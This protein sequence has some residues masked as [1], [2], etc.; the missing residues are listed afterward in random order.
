MSLLSYKLLETDF[1]N[2]AGFSYVYVPFNLVEA[3]L[4]LACA[5]YVLLRALRR[6]NRAIEFVYSSAFVVF[7]LTDLM[8][9]FYL[10]VWLLLLKGL[11]LLSLL[12][13]RKNVI[14]LYAGAKL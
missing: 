6:N 4:W 12:I 14:R 11:V 10:P 1:D 5:A 3:L 9:V 2:F 7:A 13:L 8:E